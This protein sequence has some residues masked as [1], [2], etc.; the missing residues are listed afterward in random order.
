MAEQIEILENVD[1]IDPKLEKTIKRNIVLYAAGNAVSSLGTYMYNFAVGLYVLKLTG[2][3]ASFAL[4]LLFGMIPRIILSPFAG[5]LA[6]RLDRKKMAVSMDI[7]SGVL[8]IV[9]FSLSQLTTLSLMM[10]YLSSALLTVFNTFFGISIGASVPN[11]VDENRLMKINSIRAMVDSLSS[12]VGP[13][14]GGFAYSIVGIELFLLFNGI[15][16]VCSGVSE[17]F[18]NFNIFNRPVNDKTQS[19]SIKEN[20]KEGI[21]YL[22]NH[23]L[24]IGIL[25]YALFLNFIV[26]S[27]T[28][29]LPYTSVEVLGAT[30]TQYGLVQMGFPIG[31]L[32][33][34]TLYSILRK[35]SKKVFLQTARYTLLLGLVFILFGAPASPLMLY[36]SN[37]TNLVA[38]FIIS[39]IM[40]AII[41][42]IN[43]PL[44][45][46]MQKSI[47][48][49]F[50]G[51]VGGVLSMASQLI[52][53]LGLIIFGF[54]IDHISSYLLPIIS[55]ILILCIAT[56]MFNDKEMLEL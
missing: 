11:M 40:G 39:I 36:F 15:S 51:R 16:F 21:L 27:V 18:I 44:Q 45:V 1:S 30:P 53:P 3:G 6:D 2:S 23:K 14:L 37:F 35:D 55:G 38:I 50:R 34:S 8:M 42:S 32:V 29:S 25:K 54:L 52:S 41:V 26:M 13:L 43:I 20:L 47:D 48:D 31:L 12:L 7:L 33:M 24:I 9:M 56:L 4:A 17:I 28:I 10:I 19:Q 22:R 46:M 49:E 5:A